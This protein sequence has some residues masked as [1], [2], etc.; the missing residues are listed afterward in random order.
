MNCCRGALI[1]VF[2]FFI[3]LLASCGS[4]SELDYD[5]LSTSELK[6]LVKDDY[7]DL[8]VMRLIE[9]EG[10]ESIV[11][12]VALWHFKSQSTSGPIHASAR[13]YLHDHHMPKDIDSYEEFIKWWEIK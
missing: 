11:P 8:A 2:W 6:K 10:D 5:N 13:G 1:L 7:N 9:V 4:V 3:S 12:I